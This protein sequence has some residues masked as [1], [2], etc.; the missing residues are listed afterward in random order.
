MENLLLSEYYDQAR[1]AHQHTSFDPEKRGEQYIRSCSQELEND[2]QKLDVEY[3]EEYKSKYIQKML[4]WFSAKSRCASTMIT[5]GSNF[6][7]R[8]AEKANQSEHN[9]MNEFIEFRENFFK[10]IEKAKDR[11]KSPDQKRVEFFDQYKKEILSSSVSIIEIDKGINR[12]SSR[13]LLVTNLFGKIQTIIKK[14]DHQ[15][16]EMTLDLLKEIHSSDEI[17]KPIFTSRHKVWKLLEATEAQREAIADR[18]AQENIEI[19]FDGGVIILNYQEN[20]LQITHDY[21]P[22]YDVRKELKYNG[23]KWSPFNKAWQRLL[24]RNSI[25]V[26]QKITGATILN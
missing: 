2:L 17:V 23:F 8:R 6:N 13:P 11:A 4:A 22:S 21:V 9:R 3:H 24:N 10:R 25:S 12:Y 7:V 5:G 1:A 18:Q 20:R 26:A 15:L 16:S 19:Q 14:G